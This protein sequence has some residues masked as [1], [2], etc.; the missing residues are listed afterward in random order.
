MKPEARQLSFHLYSVQVK[1]EIG[2]CVLGDPPGLP[3]RTAGCLSGH[4]L[5]QFEVMLHSLSLL[6]FKRQYLCL[7]QLLSCRTNRTA[8]HHFYF[9]KC[10]GAAHSQGGEWMSAIISCSGRRCFAESMEGTG[11]TEIKATSPVNKAMVISLC[12]WQLRNHRIKQERCVQGLLFWFSHCLFLAL[13]SF[14]SVVPSLAVR[15]WHQSSATK[16]VYYVP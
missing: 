6:L 15:C 5:G 12:Q 3:L 1:A 10:L 4:Q 2:A 7:S 16:G 8:H 11:K 13:K 9:Q 14:S